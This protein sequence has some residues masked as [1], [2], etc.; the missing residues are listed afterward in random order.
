MVQKDTFFSCLPRVHAS[1][2][3][4]VLCFFLILSNPDAFLFLFV[5]PASPN[6]GVT[7]GCRLVAPDPEVESDDQRPFITASFTSIA[8]GMEVAP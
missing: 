5:K 8:A 6:V 7:N 1:L 3:D 2:F 4:V